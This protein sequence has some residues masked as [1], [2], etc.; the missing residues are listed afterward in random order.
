MWARPRRAVALALALTLVAPSAAAACAGADT[1]PADAAPQRA[2]RTVICL[3]NRERAA[4]GLSALRANRALRR[5]ARGH[6][7]DMVVRGYFAHDTPEGRTPAAR[8]LAYTARADR[9]TVGENLAW[10]SGP[11]ATPR[12]TVINWMQSPTH[13][14][15]VLRPVFREVGIGVVKGS[16]RPQV[17]HAFTYAASFGRR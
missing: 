7:R 9:W 14:A 8:A 5:A 2:A 17:A 16:P 1:A 13:R 4:H 10:G 15:N 12:Q 3:I 6:A 11:I